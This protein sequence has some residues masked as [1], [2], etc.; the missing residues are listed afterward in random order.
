MIEN[1]IPVSAFGEL[2][3]RLAV[4]LGV[5]SIMAVWELAAPRRK[6]IFEKKTR[7]AANLAITLFNTMLVRL[8][9]PLAPVVMAVWA[10]D[11]QWGLLN[12]FDIPSWIGIIITLLILDC[13][14]YLQ[15]VMFH[16]LPILWRLHLVHH[17]DLDIDVT[18]GL[19]F[20]PL[21][22]ILSLFVKVSVVLLL[23]P[24][25]VAVIVFEAVLNWTS[26]F[27]QANLV[28]RILL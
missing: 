22:I 6:L 13:A 1:I 14:V 10:K 27:N 23:G 20:H 12:Y 4:F 26:L 17:A 24:D 15:H 9:A 8:A 5:F 21:E 3:T 7:W 11:N 25:P 28:C 18:T 2:G 16:T 19:R